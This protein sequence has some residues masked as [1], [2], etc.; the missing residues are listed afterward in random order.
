M[1]EALDTSIATAF[2]HLTGRELAPTTPGLGVAAVAEAKAQA[3]DAAAAA[4]AEAPARA[5]A[6]AGVYQLTTMVGK[7]L[8]Y[9]NDQ[10]FVYE[11]GTLELRSDGTFTS[12]KTMG[13]G[14]KSN[15]KG[16]YT[17]HRRGDRVQGGGERVRADVR[18]E[19][20]P[21]RRGFDHRSSRRHGLF[22]DA[23]GRTLSADQGDAGV[24]AGW[25]GSV[26]LPRRRD[27]AGPAAA[28]AAFRCRRR[29]V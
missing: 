25:L 7:P 5:A 26:S 8:P 2:L 3:A 12:S 6:A 21:P 19:Q 28:T 1:K 16:T 4:A 20:G 27:A 15:Y 22:T 14:K 11:G 10:G 13:G 17:D 24:P 9:K 18:P 29:C 23:L